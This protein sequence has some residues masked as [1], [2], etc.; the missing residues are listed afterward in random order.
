MS[1]PAIAVV[2]AM[3]AAAGVENAAAEATAAAVEAATPVIAV[4]SATGAAEAQREE[5]VH[6][7]DG[8]AS[9]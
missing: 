9:R 5:L 4:V 2:L 6:S 3:V 1:G 7:S 8:D